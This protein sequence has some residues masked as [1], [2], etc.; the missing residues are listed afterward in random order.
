MWLLVEV[1]IVFVGVSDL[2]QMVGGYCSE[3]LRFVV[4]SEV[5][6]G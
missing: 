6:K 1:V 2:W 4:G 3:V 5:E